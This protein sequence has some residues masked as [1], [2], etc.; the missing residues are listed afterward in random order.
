MSFNFLEERIEEVPAF[1]HIIDQ[2]LT[3]A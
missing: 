3:L 1:I 2:A